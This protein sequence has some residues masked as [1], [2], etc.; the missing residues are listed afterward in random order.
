[1]PGVP[2]RQSH[3]YRRNGTTNLYAAS[4]AGHVL[5]PMM[6]PYSASKFAVVVISEALGARLRRSGLEEADIRI[7][8]KGR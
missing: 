5:G 3:D 7:I 4:L 1:M 8:E 6:A 2:Q